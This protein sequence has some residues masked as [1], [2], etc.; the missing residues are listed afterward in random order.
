MVSG[1]RIFFF[2]TK[3]TKKTYGRLFAIEEKNLGAVIDTQLQM[4]IFEKLL[5]ENRIPW[6]RKYSLCKRNARLGESLIDYLLISCK[7]KIYLEI[8]SAVLRDANSAMYPDCPTVR[9]QKHIQELTQYVNSGGTAYI[10]FMAS[11]PEITGFK[12]NLQADPLLYEFLL[13]AWNSRVQVKSIAFY[14]NPSDG[15]FNVYN[16]DLPIFLS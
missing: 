2:P 1:K 12:P 15:F 13:K 11:L 3:N 14:F 4:R 10:V 8:K 5:Q 9:G 6:L 7:D 16:T